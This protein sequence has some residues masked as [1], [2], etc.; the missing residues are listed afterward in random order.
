MQK[1]EELQG[2]CSQLSVLPT[3]I[4]A[5]MYRYDTT[6]HTGTPRVTSTTLWYGTPSYDSM[7]EIILNQGAT[8]LIQEDMYEEN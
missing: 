6:A 5:K 8:S 7:P 2:D 1:E 4:M 3:E